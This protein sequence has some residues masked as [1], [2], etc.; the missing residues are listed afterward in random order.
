MIT[1]T[2]SAKKLRENLREIIMDIHN[3]DAEY[4]LEYVKGLKVKLVPVSIKTKESNLSLFIKTR[5]WKGDKEY[6]NL[7]N[8]DIRKMTYGQKY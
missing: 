1:K 6:K 7:T 4:V 2:I 8:D 5:V 3:N